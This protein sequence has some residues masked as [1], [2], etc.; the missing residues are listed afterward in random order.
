M[1]FVQAHYHELRAERNI[2]NNK[3]YEP[4]HNNAMKRKVTSAIDGLSMGDVRRRLDCVR[5]QWLVANH[6]PF[7][8]TEPTVNG[9]DDAQEND[10][11]NSEIH[12]EVQEFA[13]RFIHGQHEKR[14][15]KQ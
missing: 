13:F 10:I 9:R 5:K 7:F 4:R 8:L 6:T 14:Y 11:I 15:K 1:F 3:K 12:L 2:I